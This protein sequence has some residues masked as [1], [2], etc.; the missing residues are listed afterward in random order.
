MENKEKLELETSIKLNFYQNVTNICVV[1]LML[2]FGLAI[3]LYLFYLSSGMMLI[4]TG[5]MVFFV[6]ASVLLTCIVLF[7][8]LGNIIVVKNYSRN[9]IKYNKI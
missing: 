9:I 6:I 1:A 3:L 2:I 5:T 8:W 7:S 4:G